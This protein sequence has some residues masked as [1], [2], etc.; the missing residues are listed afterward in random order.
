M[1][2]ALGR[3]CARTAAENP[4]DFQGKAPRGENPIDDKPSFTG[5]NQSNQFSFYSFVFFIFL[6]FSLSDFLKNFLE[7]LFFSPFC[8]LNFLGLL[9][10]LPLPV[11]LAFPILYGNVKEYLQYVF[12]QPPPKNISYLGFLM[13]YRA[14]L[15]PKLKVIDLSLIHI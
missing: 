1:G 3:H 13:S 4:I 2:T 14:Q 10:L 7:F 9:L 11:S 6:L 15:G 12:L 8:L 5:E